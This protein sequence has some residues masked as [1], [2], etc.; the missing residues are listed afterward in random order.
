MVKGTTL[1]SLVV[2][3]MVMTKAMVMII[4][5][6]EFHGH[7]QTMVNTMGTTAMTVVKSVVKTM[8]NTIVETMVM[9]M[10]PTIVMT[11][12]MTLAMTIIITLGGVRVSICAE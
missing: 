4:V 10:A 12:V 8:V 2:R 1:V 9:A 5:K 7:D 3:P 6:T 11:M